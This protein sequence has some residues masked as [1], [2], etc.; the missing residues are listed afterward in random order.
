MTATNDWSDDCE[1][2]LEELRQN[3]VYLNKFHKLR[4]FYFKKIIIYFRLPT[5]IISSF[6]S[7]ASGLGREYLSQPDITSLVVLMSL[8]VSILNSIELYMKINETTELELETSKKY[9]QLSIDV[10][11]VLQLNRI[12]RKISGS[13]AL[14]KF[15]RDYTELYEASALVSNSYNDKLALIPKKPSMFKQSP[16][17]S[18]SSSS[19][20]SIGSN[21]MDPEIGNQ[22]AEL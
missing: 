9:Y 6:A 4:Y 15:Y 1:Q 3:C 20:S 5:I 7:V 2:L 21:P 17:A 10:H 12:N 18:S 11:K 14:E 16:T 22:T 13:D 8:S 19:I